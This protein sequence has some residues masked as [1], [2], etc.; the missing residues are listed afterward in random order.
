M[1]RFPP[2]QPRTPLSILWHLISLASLTYSFN[3]LY[4]PG[5][6]HEFMDKQY[7]GHWQF[8]TILSLAAS[9]LVFAFALLYDIAPLGIFAR[10]KTSVAVLAV[11]AEGLVGLLYWAL[12]L[13]DPA[14]LNPDNAEFRL[15]FA[16]DMSMHGLPA[17]YLW[18]DFLL[19]SPPFP[20]RVRPI[21]LATGATAAYSVWMEH[22]ASINK[23]F[24][25]PM[26]DGMAP[27][28]RSLFYLLQIPVLIGLY[29]AA[30]GIH[31]AVRGASH[32]QVEA[33]G[34]AEAERE[35]RKA[36]EEVKK[37]L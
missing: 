29:K 11:P 31:A 12:T 28:S 19:F 32:A 8:L 22:C 37:G 24:P 36:K 33:R 5:P 34:A 10:L 15:P 3:F 6:M 1:A 2:S 14:L 30:N 27:L 18:V 26:L 9:W 35:V 20:K 21:L 17:V 7:A 13:Y 25:Y 4:T 16:V 23:H